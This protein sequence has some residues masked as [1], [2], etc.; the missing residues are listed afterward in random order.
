MQAF[1]DESGPLPSGNQFTGETSVFFRALSM[2][3]RLRP[4]EMMVNRMKSGLHVVSL[5][6]ALSAVGC[7]ESNPQPSPENG[8]DQPPA[9]VADVV[10]VET[11]DSGSDSAKEPDVG[12]DCKKLPG[13][14]C[15]PGEPHG[16]SDDPSL[17][18]RCRED[19]T[20]W[21][22]E[23]CVG[24]GTG[25]SFCMTSDE[26]PDGY[27]T[28][29]VPGEKRCQDDQMVL[30]CSQYGLEWEEYN[31]CQG[32]VTGQICVQG[33]CFKLCG[34]EFG[35][36][37]SLGVPA[38]TGC[39]FWA[40]QLG[41][42]LHPTAEP[43]LP[44]T[45]SAQFAVAVVNVHPD[46]P[47][48]ISISG[49]DGKL[50][51]DCAGT[52][53]S[54]EPIPAGGY[55]TYDLSCLS[56]AADKDSYP[57][58][59]VRSAIPVAAY[60]F[61][62]LVDSATYSA[63]AS[64]L[65]NWWALGKH[66]LILGREQTQGSQ[67][68]F[69]AV[70]AARSGNTEVTVDVT[71]PAKAEVHP[72]TEEAFEVL[73]PGDPLSVTLQTNEVLT[74]RTEDVGADLTGSRILSTREVVVF[75]GSA[76]AN[77]PNTAAC[78]A[79]VCAW[80]GKTPCADMSDCA[81]MLTTCCADH[82]EQQLP[83]VNS[84]GLTYAA[85]K[86]SARNK[87]KD[88]YRVVAAE[89]GTLVTVTPPLLELPLL[90]SGEWVEFESA[91]DFEIVATKP[92][93]VG[94]FVAGRDAPNPNIGG[95]GQPAEDAGFGDPSFILLV[96]AEQARQEYGFMVPEGY[97]SNYVTVVAPVKGNGSVAAVW[98]DCAQT[99]V[100]RIEAE[101]APLPPVEF[102]AFG[103]GKI[104]AAKLEVEEGAHRVWAKEPV[105]VY[106]YGYAPYASYGYP[107]GMDVRDLGY[108][109]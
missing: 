28:N 67:G 36:G 4:N 23:A 85:T 84:W 70:V 53:I 43:A 61:N 71:A 5:L 75:A 3:G 30:Q 13:M 94:Q 69:V 11:A 100:A 27:C 62:S 78:N 95:I 77:V 15:C 57:V 55:R 107:A 88:V 45:T 72:D 29:C 93:L 34:D 51:V 101:C 82:L 35:M 8:G 92:V 59:E 64:L 49:A 58:Y 98:L 26:F 103:S 20:G 10:A 56:G 89:N 47:V 39:H 74:I 19:G 97:G 42:E 68:S 32:E 104:A 99:D 79:G 73:E 7:I 66:H 76:G 17:I 87:E 46:W 25:K 63:D 86:T 60:Q 22:P 105:V 50:P 24:D 21:E 54:E 31:N 38:N 1:G 80:D 18:L 91:Q 106:V 6:V 52:S 90:D 44:D 109:K 16:C 9:G 40:V 83:P 12:A 65:L 41:N 2:R 14:V 96:P 33:T 37:S 81:D 48:S 108:L 102:V